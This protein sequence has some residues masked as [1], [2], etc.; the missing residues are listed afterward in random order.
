MTEVV[1][2]SQGNY[3]PR[4]ANNG[5]Y[6]LILIGIFISFAYILGGL[7]FLLIGIYLSFSFSGIDIDVNKGRYRDYAYYFGIKSNS[8]WK[9][10]KNYPYLS[11]L[12]TR[13]SEGTFSRSNRYTE[14][15]E[16]YFDLFFLSKT[17]RK[18]IFIERFNDLEAAK[19]RA[20]QLSE[21]MHKPVARYQP[22]GSIRKK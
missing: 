18:K 8:S 22:E 21:I 20:V 16:R 3:F 17:H 1:S 5:G 4:A 14:M 7:P 13:V 9:E 10:L 11:I 2:I 15:T 12:Q 19:K 6:L